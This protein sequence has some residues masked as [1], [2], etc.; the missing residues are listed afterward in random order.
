[1]PAQQHFSSRPSPAALPLLA[2]PGLFL[3][4][5]LLLCLGTWEP[6]A[7]TGKDEFFLGLRTPME[8]MARQEWW[9][10]FLDGAPRIRK[11]PLLYWLTRL[12][13]ETF[14]ISLFSARLV[15]VLFGA[16]LVTATV[17]IGRRL[18]GD[19]GI[20]LFA[21][22]LLLTFLGLNTESRRLML[23]I[24]VAAL[25]TLAFWA[26]LTW[27]ESPRARWLGLAALLLGAGFLLKGPIV[28]LVCGGGMLGLMAIH[29][30][31]WHELFKRWPAVLGSL[32]LILVIALPWF[33]LVRQLHPEAAALAYADEMEARQLAHF[34]LD[35][36]P[37]LLQIALP[38]S[39]VALAL[40]WQNR[41]TIWQQTGEDRLLLV[42]LLATCLPFLLV[43]TFERYLV[44]SLVPLAL[45]LAWQMRNL[46]QLPT[47]PAR[48][49]MGISLVLGGLLAAFA[50]RFDLGG[51]YFWLPTA[52][53]LAWAW[54]RGRQRL[55]WLA[56]PLL[57]WIALLW[58]VFPALGV[59]AIPPQA[60]ELGK[61]RQ[62]AMYDGP[63]PAL[64]P[65][66]S[67]RPLQH[68]PRVEATQARQLM[69]ADGLIFTD[70][71]D[72]PRLQRQLAEAGLAAQVEGGYRTLASAGS[73]LRFARKGATLDDWKRAWNTRNLDPLLTHIV[74]LKLVPAQTVAP[75]P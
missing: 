16:G 59:N 46:E 31:P 62:I 43:R 24:P 50:W 69:A 44:G 13:Y 17:G 30:F 36:I 61:T 2:W 29:R 25:S 11:P 56:A 71:D 38:W 35:M 51:W 14:G 33:V 48:L 20:A 66:L 55:H 1:M 18:L 4:A 34:S 52:L 19:N 73:G 37:G 21:G 28:A 72:L 23:D 7:L 41:K 58:G 47:W 9:V 60:L 68:W 39:F 70:R 75:P 63:Q 42:W 12:S 74:W 5:A 57:Y 32:L 3:I 67:G 49:G 22:G 8:M 53:Y 54:S 6:T 40:V 27:R 15:T 65:I 45:L 10:P 26:F 64:L